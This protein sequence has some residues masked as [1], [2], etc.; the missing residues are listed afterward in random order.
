MSNTKRD[1]SYRG[2]ISERISTYKVVPRHIYKKKNQEKSWEYRE[3]P[4]FDINFV[5]ISKDGTL[6]DI[7]RVGNLL[8]GLPSV[9]DK[10]VVNLDVDEL[11][12]E[13]E[14]PLSDD[15]S[16]WKRIEP[17]KEFKKL[18]VWYKREMAKEKNGIKRT[19]IREK[20]CNDRNALV[21]K[22]KKF[23]DDEFN[24]REYGL[25][26]KTDKDIHYITGENWMFLKHYYLTESNIYPNF[27]VTAM[28]SY[29]HWEACVADSRTWGEIRGKARRT[30]WTV[31]SASMA[32]NCFTITKYAEIPI[33]SERS[34]L[35]GKLF[36]GK[37]A[38]SFKYYPIY[39]KPLIDLPNDEPQSKLTITHETDD[40][41]TSVIDFYPTK[42]TAYDSTKVINISI[43]DEIGKWINSSL[44]E[45]V[46]R[47]SKCHTE[48][49]ATGRFGSTA[50]DY[51]KGGGKEFETEFKDANPNERNKLGRTTN[52]LTA[53]FIDVCYTMTEPFKYFDEWGYSI[54]N[55]PIEPILNEEGKI[56]EIGAITHWNAT[57][58]D[59]KEKK[60]KKK[61]NGFLRDAPRE[62]KHMFR[63][64]GGKNNDFDIDNLNNHA[65]YLDEL[66]KEDFTEK[67]FVGNLRFEGEKFNSPIKWIPDP[68]GKFKTTWIPNVELQNQYSKKDFHGKNIIMPDNSHIGCFGVDSYDI[69]GQASDGR[70][71]DGA[72]V[73]FTKFGLTGAPSNSFFLIYR[74]RPKKRN[75]FFDDVIMACMFFG[76]YALI[77]SNKSRLLEYMY[78][79]SVT[80]FALRR[81]DKKWKN[82]TESEKLWGGIPS[83]TPVIQDQTS[84]LQDYISD[85][86][87]VD[88][89]NDCK[90][91]H[92]E[93]IEEWIEFKP[94]NRKEYD[95][96]VASGM[97]KMGAQ[98]QEKRKYADSDE[99]NSG[100]LSFSSF[101]A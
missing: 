17:P 28:E 67:I 16:K 71:S 43:N 72:I 75:D 49:G 45:F 30:S 29:W 48:G 52:G 31:E 61:I 15:D 57:Y 55:D 32:L 51:N 44:T 80:G 98:Y 65:D 77:E 90:V 10:K 100:G 88:L 6:G 14:H 54:V 50:G 82:L 1:R 27:R 83:S 97:A 38:N 36:T 62:V 24:K 78:D 13:L 73:G 25:F 19:N 74:E 63:S 53:F 64:E 66:T 84:G 99:S 2:R 95:L 7:Y 60:D 42:D 85:F 101:S 11:G 18:W 46:S 56:T 86:V 87:G 92:K 70:G 39:F 47:H 20:F 26:I 79:N 9:K 94:N 21:R 68:N 40:S 58:N 23:V 69:I 59:L 81:Q 33:V 35:A 41:E 37:I 91:Y 3:Y 5:C 76:F 12:N 96:A 89:E 34:E 93:L 4:E 8:I 22:H